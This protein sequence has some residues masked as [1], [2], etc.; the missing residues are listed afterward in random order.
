MNR[1][2]LKSFNKSPL[3]TSFITL[4]LLLIAHMCLSMTTLA[5]NYYVSFMGNDGWSGTIDD[6][7]FLPD[8]CSADGDTSDCTDGPWRTIQHAVDSTGAGDIVTVKA[9]VYGEYIRISTSGALNSHRIVKGERGADGQWLTIIDPG[10]LVSGWKPAAEI[11]SGVFKVSQDEVGFAF[12]EMT[13]NDRRIGRIRDGMMADG[14]GLEILQR[15]KDYKLTME[16]TGVE[17]SYWDGIEALAANGNKSTY[18]R[19]RNG[20]DPN[21]KTIKAYKIQNVLGLYDGASYNTIRDFLIIGGEHGVIL[22]NGAHNNIIGQNKIMCNRIRLGVYHGAHDNQ[23]HLNE[24]TMGYYGYDDLGAW[25]GGEEKLHGIREHV[26]KEFKYTIGHNTSH[27]SAVSMMH[28]GSGNNFDSNFIYQGLIGITG[29]ASIDKVTRETKFANNNIQNMSSVGFTS[30]F[31]LTDTKFFGNRIQNCNINLRLH[32]INQLEESERVVFIYDNNFWQPGEIGKQIHVHWLSNG[33]EISPAT[34]WIYHNTFSGGA[35]GIYNARQSDKHRSPGIFFLNNI[36]SAEKPYY[37][38]KSSSE[39]A[40]KDQIIGG[41]DYN[42]V[43][44]LSSKSQIKT[45]GEHNLTSS[46]AMWQDTSKPDFTIPEEFKTALTP[47]G[48]DLSENFILREISY[49]PLPGIQHDRYSG[50]AVSIGSWPTI[51]I[52]NRV[53]ILDPTQ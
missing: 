11:G 26:Y 35:R 7:G 24:M 15:H 19:F 27:D 20:D 32:N 16:G 12:E 9:G 33:N 38:Q 46:R 14:S 53:Q 44:P 50:N 5:A 21:G 18:I 52:P 23:V 4:N 10:K 43:G 40:V 13:V 41:L 2:K 29:S 36:L 34:Y 3:T 39:N 42:W 8:N 47:A 31:G 28:A 25:G 45:L 48:I 1:L 17:I 22:T 49:K 51:H 6:G 30:S 37:N